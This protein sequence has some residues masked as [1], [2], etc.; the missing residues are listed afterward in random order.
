MKYTKEITDQM[1]LDYESGMSALEISK[2]LDVQ[3]RSVIAKLASLGVYQKKSYVNKR[4]EPPIRKAEY[5]ERIA[6]LL[7]VNLE[8]LESLEKVNKHVLKLL[9]EN[10]S[11]PKVE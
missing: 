6:E 5:I 9:E 1:I 7:D 8:L 11:D 10:L 3:E 4:G 2:K